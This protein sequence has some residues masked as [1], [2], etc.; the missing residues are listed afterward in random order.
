MTCL[1]SLGLPSHGTY[2][3]FLYTPMTPGGPLWCPCCWAPSS[4]STL[5]CRGPATPLASVT[6]LAAPPRP[7]FRLTRSRSS[8]ASGRSVSAPEDPNRGVSDPS[9]WNAP[10][11]RIAHPI[12]SC[13]GRRSG[14]ACALPY[15]AFRRSAAL[16]TL[17]HHRRPRG[18][19]PG[20]R[21][22]ACGTAEITTARLGEGQPRGWKRRTRRPAGSSSRPTGGSD[23]ARA[24]GTNCGA[25]CSLPT[26]S[27]R[28]ARRERARAAMRNGSGAADLHPRLLAPFSPPYLALAGRLE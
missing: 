20:T 9:P 4:R 10:R 23:R 27:I 5:A 22:A 3:F 14:G 13:R 21:V 1:R 19:P 2:V 6:S 15:R 7:R 11:T 12:T 25:G 24:P 26:S 18:V 8:D 16:D 28:P 17:D